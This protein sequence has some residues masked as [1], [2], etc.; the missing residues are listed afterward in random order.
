M[1]SQQDRGTVDLLWVVINTG[2]THQSLLASPLD[3]P[4]T[5]CNCDSQVGCFINNS[6]KVD[7]CTYSCYVSLKFN[8]LKPLN[9]PV[10]LNYCPV[11]HV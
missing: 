9:E 7:D 6:P 3:Y 2:P 11:I 5:A 1:S 8:P 10:H 4:S